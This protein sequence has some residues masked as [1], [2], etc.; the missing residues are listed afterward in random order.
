[1]T[2]DCGDKKNV[3]RPHQLSLNYRSHSGIVALGKAVVELLKNNFG[4]DFMAK[5][6]VAALEGRMWLCLLV[7]RACSR[8]KEGA[9]SI[10]CRQTNVYPTRLILSYVNIL[11]EAI[12]DSKCFVSQQDQNHLSSG[13]VYKSS[14][15]QWVIGKCNFFSWIRKV[16]KHAFLRPRP[17]VVWAWPWRFESRSTWLLDR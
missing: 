14:R 9:K 8:F 17:W 1:M 3:P 13:W 11:R 2:E 12:H 16:G 15:V 4:V 7:C 5:P 6:D 10:E